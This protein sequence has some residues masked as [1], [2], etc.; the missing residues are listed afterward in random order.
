MDKI[1]KTLYYIGIMASILS[2]TFITVA[3]AQ[4]KNHQKENKGETV[5]VK[6]SYSG[7]D[8]VGQKLF[9]Q[10]KKRIR[11]LK[12]F[13]LVSKE[14]YAHIN[15][16]IVSFDPDIDKDIKGIRTVYSVIWLI[17]ENNKLIDHFIG[18]SRK[19]CIN[20]AADRIVAQTDNIIAKTKNRIHDY[21]KD[22]LIKLTLDM[23][24][25]LLKDENKELLKQVSDL[26]IKISD[27]EGKVEK[28]K[29]S[30]VQKLLGE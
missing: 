24:N 27:L 12:S 11:H 22:Q 14:K 5:L 8:I 1:R 6:I 20:N 16:I 21:A 9:Y 23:E 13:V 2:I 3:H 28:E 4:E 18:Y 17:E 26:K 30:W 15:L 10:I 7:D 29:K 19:Q 25:E